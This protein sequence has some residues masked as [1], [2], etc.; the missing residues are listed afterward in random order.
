[1]WKNKFSIN[2]TPTRTF[3]P[4]H[5]WLSWSHILHQR[6][7]ATIY[8]FCQLFPSGPQIHMGNLWNLSHFSRYQHFCPRQQIGNQC[9]LQT[10]RFAQLLT[11]LV[12]PPIS[13]Q[14]LNSILPN[15][16]DSVGSAAK[17]QTLTPN[18][19]VQV[20]DT[21]VINMYQSEE[22]IGE[23][24][25]LDGAGDDEEDTVGKCSSQ[26]SSSD[27]DADIDKELRNQNW[28]FLRTT[29]SGRNISVNQKYG[30]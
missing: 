11:V 21:S 29:R 25:K 16:S 9:P 8:R 6:R 12:F 7:I 3:W 22:Q 2:S 18:A 17:I 27:S 30:L 24:V 1:M 5:R 15:F 23:K 20:R 19:Q 14:R 28:S 26:S 4:L 13:L 10:H